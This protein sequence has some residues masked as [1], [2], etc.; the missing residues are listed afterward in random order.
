MTSIRAEI[1]ENPRQGQWGGYRSSNWHWLCRSTSK[2]YHRSSRPPDGN[3]AGFNG[4]YSGPMINQEDEA[5]LIWSDTRNEDPFVPANR[6][7]HGQDVFTA[8]P[9]GPR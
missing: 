5:H 8:R 2:F 3:Q 4:D 1:S 9:P 7:L 6:V